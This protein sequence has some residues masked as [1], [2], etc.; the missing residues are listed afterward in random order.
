MSSD[1][2]IPFTQVLEKADVLM[3]WCCLRVP[4]IRPISI[5]DDPSCRQTMIHTYEK[6]RPLAPAMRLCWEENP[7]QCRGALYRIAS[8]FRVHPRIAD[9]LMRCHDAGKGWMFFLEFFS[10]LGL[11]YIQHRCGGVLPQTM[12]SENSVPGEEWLSRQDTLT[13]AHEA[14]S[15][16]AAFLRNALEK[17]MTGT[18]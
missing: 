7:Q 11:W 9:A 16:S 14:S 4:Q 3:R 17:I 6:L 10:S 15:I 2:K 12:G 13:F 8:A 1:K 18:E 5:G